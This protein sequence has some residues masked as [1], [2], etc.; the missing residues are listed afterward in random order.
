MEGGFGRVAAL[1]SVYRDVACWIRL[2]WS[3]GVWWGCFLRKLSV[4]EVEFFGLRSSSG[5]FLRQVNHC[6]AAAGSIH[7]LAL[8]TLRYFRKFSAR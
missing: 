2:S 7:C 6:K 1:R 5:E 8:G 4:Y 3:R